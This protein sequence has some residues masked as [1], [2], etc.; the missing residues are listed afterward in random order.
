CRNDRAASSEPRLPEGEAGAIL[1]QAIEAAGGWEAWASKQTTAFVSTTTISNPA[2]GTTS[3]TLGLY[4]FP[5]HETGKIRFDSLGLIEPIAASFAGEDAWM[6]RDAAP[7]TDPA[8]LDVLRFNAVSTAFWFG[9]P[10]RLA[11]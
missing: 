11:E 6:T 1:A 3:E 10:F 2:A 7:V 5:L 9:L 4:R 8:E